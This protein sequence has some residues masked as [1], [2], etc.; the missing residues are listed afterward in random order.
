MCVIQ[1]QNQFVF[2]IHKTSRAVAFHT[3]PVGNLA[4]NYTLLTVQLNAVF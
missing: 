4:L 2:K 3:L 1:Q